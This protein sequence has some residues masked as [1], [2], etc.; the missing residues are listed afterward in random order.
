MHKVSVIIPNYNHASFLKDR[1]DS[2]LH[3]T[4]RDFEVIILDD[5][6][7]DESRKIIDQYRGHEKI[8]SVVYNTQNSGGVFKQWV[9]G[10]G[11]AKG[12]YVW[13]AESDDYASEYFLAETVAQ[14]EKNDCL[15]MVFTGATVINEEN[16]VL[17]HSPKLE[18]EIL[19]SLHSAGN[20][21]DRS[22]ISQFLVADMVIENASGVLFR[23]D[24]LQRVN[25]QELMNFRHTG[26]RFT[27]V[28][29]ALQTAIL[30]LPNSLNF[31]R[32]HNNNTTK[33]NIENGAIHADRLRVLSYYGPQLYNN[34]LN[35]ESANRF[36]KNN[37]LHFLNWGSYNEH[38]SLLP[39]LR[40]QKG[41]S[42]L[43]YSAIKGYLRLL[44]KNGRRSGIVR[45]VF[46]RTL[47][48]INSFDK[49][50]QQ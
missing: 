47:L 23:N 26:D 9:K 38:R 44:E 41:I 28:G 24:A 21:I 33:K 14:L 46:Y 32:T 5:C 6:S 11:L 25:L 34:I 19:T 13:I 43:S 18:S 16:Q 31:I 20:I 15:G 17:R 37:Y 10:I 30:Y 2:V 35:R 22:N 29:I 40:R 45:S 39:I 8:T 4:F 49:D 36:Y 42:L 1:I 48:F 12:K 27:Y 7:T 3:Q 50:Y